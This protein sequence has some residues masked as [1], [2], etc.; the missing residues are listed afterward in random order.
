MRDIALSLIISWM[1]LVSLKRPEI[2]AYL[3]AWLSLMN[4]HRMTYGFAHDLPWAM[5][6]ALFGLMGAL[7]SRHKSMPRSAGVWLLALLWAWMSLT[8]LTSINPGDAVLERWIFVSK[9]MLMFFVALLVVQGRSQIEV[10]VAVVAVSLAF[11]GVKGGI[12]TVATGG[13]YRV[14]GP[15]DS[16]M[17]ENNALAVS[18]IIVLPFVY[19]FWSVTTRRWLRLALPWAML[20]MGASILGSQSRGALVGVL[21]MSI[22]LGLKSK[23]P[24]RFSLVLGALLVLLIAFMPDS[25][26]ERMSTI[27][28]HQ[29]DASATQRFY[30][31]ISMW[32][33]AVDRPLVGAGFRADNLALYAVYGPTDPKYEVA[34]G[35]PWVAHSI[36]FQALG[37]HGFVGLGLFLLIWAWVWRAAGRTAREASTVPELADWVPVLM[38]MCQVSTIG[39]LVGGA[40]LSL[41]NLDLPYYIVI[42]VILCQREVQ[43]ARGPATRAVNAS[44]IAGAGAGPAMAAGRP[45][46]VAAASPSVPAANPQPTAVST[47]VPNPVSMARP[48]APRRARPAAPGATAPHD[49]A[50]PAP[51]NRPPT[52]R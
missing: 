48:G 11:F 21:A 15:P 33:V 2:G 5:I 14:W 47:P 19:Y 28:N 34:F 6:A 1:L 51:A 13:S 32:N 16:M 42:F 49:G 3:W 12:F 39:F 38:R 9:I 20:F 46:R 22:F 50:R 17:E 26:S 45:S 30:A 31:W 41:M 4:P 23:H 7:F 37:E 8:S 25:W 24:V 44:A 40:F 29:E 18:L 35:T 27:S 36:Y 52:R 43:R 10:L